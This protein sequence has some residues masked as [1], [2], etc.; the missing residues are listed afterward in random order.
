MLCQSERGG[1][2]TQKLAKKKHIDIN[3]ARMSQ[4]HSRWRMLHMLLIKDVC[5]CQC[6]QPRVTRWKMIFFQKKTC[7]RHQG[8]KLQ[9]VTYHF[10][11]ENVQVSAVDQGDKSSGL[12]SRSLLV[13]F[14]RIQE[15]TT[16]TTVSAP[17]T[18]TR[19]WRTRWTGKRQMIEIRRENGDRLYITNWCVKWPNASAKF[20]INKK[21][22][23]C[24]RNACW[25]FDWYISPRLLKGIDWL[26]WLVRYD[27]KLIIHQVQCHDTQII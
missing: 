23:R 9:I 1:K 27:Q 3:C 18:Q 16:H 10:E 17:P 11:I 24:L 14:N 12:E 19:V 21:I 15:R 5:D 20:E 22:W 26:I 8:S 2:H 4:D 13:L 7:T 6:W 25:Q